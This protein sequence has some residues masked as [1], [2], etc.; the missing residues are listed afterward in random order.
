MEQGF[1]G[2][3]LQGIDVGEFIHARY[4]SLPKFLHRMALATM[5]L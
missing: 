2:N 5:I 3:R 1:I 4:V